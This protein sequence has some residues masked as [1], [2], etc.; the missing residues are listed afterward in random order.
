MTRPTLKFF[1]SLKAAVT[2]LSVIAILLAYSASIDYELALHKIYRAWWFSGLLIVLG[3]NLAASAW[4][5]YPWRKSQA[6]F[7]MVHAGIIVIL[8]GSLIT[9]WMGFE[10]SLVLTEG[11]EESEMAT[12]QRVVGFQGKGESWQKIPFR[13]HPLDTFRP[14]IEPLEGGWELAVKEYAPHAERVV[15]FVE[16]GQIF[17]PAIRFR[18]FN[19]QTTVE[20][21]LVAGHPDR[22]RHEMGPLIVLA[23]RV[24]APELARWKANPSGAQGQGVLK[25][26]ME[27]RVFEVNV[28]QAKNHPVPLDGSAYR[29]KVKRVLPHAMV[30]GNRLVNS[31]SSWKNPAV[32]VELSSPAGTEKHTVFTLFPD[33]DSFHGQHSPSHAKIKYE[34]PMTDRNRMVLLATPGQ[35]VYCVFLSKEGTS[36]VVKMGLDDQF[37]TP[38]MGLKVKLLQYIPQS[39]QEVTYRALPMESG[40]EGFPE[41]IRIALKKGGMETSSWVDLDRGPIEVEAG[42]SRVH[43]SFE[44]RRV[45]LG[46]SVKLKDFHVGRDPGTDRPASFSSEVEVVDRTN[47][48]TLGQKIAMNQPLVYGGYKFFQASYVPVGP[49]EP[50]V[51]ILA[52]A[53]D[54]GITL[55]YL[56]SII[57]I[58]GIAVMFYWK[59]AS[60]GR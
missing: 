4:I 53:R 19:D 47:G 50:E 43:L 58:S 17:E 42:G 12:N 6:G 56:G 31:S 13:G 40:K 59:P 26:Q 30:E 38:W 28:D 23:K 25:V 8:V 55:K 7:V 16:G 22:S 48:R 41:A 2:V 51:S 18:I 44:R 54:P 21:W 1:G 37:Q 35:P 32:E 5:R 29:I 20:E 57:L 34:A 46:F 36:R 45:P 3:V 60:E 49:G 9:Q 27:G 24:A 39:R 52:V 11:G 14:Q 33:F 15:S 10:A